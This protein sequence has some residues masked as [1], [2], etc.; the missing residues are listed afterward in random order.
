MH[1]LQIAGN[2]LNEFIN[3]Q[4]LDILHNEGCSFHNLG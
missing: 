1:T 3:G 2:F 4:L